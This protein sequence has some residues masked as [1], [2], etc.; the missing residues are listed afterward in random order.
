MQKESVKGGLK[1]RNREDLKDYKN[2]FALRKGIEQRHC[3]LDDVK[4]FWKST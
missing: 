1:C 3:V 4:K 2:L